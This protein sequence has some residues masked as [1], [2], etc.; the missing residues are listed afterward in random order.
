MKKQLTTLIALAASM[1][2]LAGCQNSQSSSNHDQQ[3]YS[4]IMDKGNNAVKNGNFAA[5]DAY[6]QA[7]L[8]T[9]KADAKAKIYAQQAH[10]LHNAQNAINRYSFAEAKN[11]LEDVQDNDNGSAKMKNYAAKLLKTLKVVQKNR[12]E[13]RNQV[14]IATN[15]NDERNYKQAQSR[16]I[17]LLSKTE[18]HK[19]YYGDLL[20]QANE[21][22]LNSSKNLKTDTT[23]A[24]SD[25]NSAANQSASDSQ[26]HGETDQIK[27]PTANGKKI[28][29]DDIQKAR[30][31]L[32]EQGAQDAAASDSDITRAIQKAAADGRSTITPADAGF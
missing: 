1:F 21:I 19:K 20:K 26:A 10:S 24:A 17:D 28:T 22:L 16:I 2:I 9:K 12:K 3:I 18:F 23:P 7:A 11:N 13:Y 25:N 29:S 27:N 14:E 6:Y 32:Q 30:K 31:Q 8:T 15:A 4:S 5:A